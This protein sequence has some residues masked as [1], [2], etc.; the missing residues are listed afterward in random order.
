MEQLKIISLCFPQVGAATLDIK[1]GS[2]SSTPTET[3]AEVNGCISTE[4]TCNY[5]KRTLLLKRLDKLPF[6]SIQKIMVR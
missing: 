1:T 4:H 5:P 2:F 6:V 3:C